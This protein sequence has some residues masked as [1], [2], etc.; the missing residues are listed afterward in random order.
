MQTHIQLANVH[1]LPSSA[2]LYTHFVLCLYTGRD[3]FALERVKWTADT[4]SMQALSILYDCNSYYLLLKIIPFG[5]V[6]A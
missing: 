2:A 4:L 1:T 3:K 6:H 5:I